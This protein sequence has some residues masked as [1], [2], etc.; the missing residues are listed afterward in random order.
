MIPTTISQGRTVGKKFTT[1]KHWRADPEAFEGGD[2]RRAYKH[3]AIEPPGLRPTRII[4]K[5]LLDDDA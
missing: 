4:A 5:V 3:N 1:N 2:C